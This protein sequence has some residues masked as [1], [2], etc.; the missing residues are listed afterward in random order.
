MLRWGIY[1]L[2]CLM[3]VCTYSI[4]EAGI[5]S[6][7]DKVEQIQHIYQLAKGGTTPFMEVDNSIKLGMTNTQIGDYCRKEKIDL[8]DPNLLFAL[9]FSEKTKKVS[10][11]T[12]LTDYDFIL[13]DITNALG[14]P[15]NLIKFLQSGDYRIEYV[16]NLHPTIPYGPKHVLAFYFTEKGYQKLSVKILGEGM[17]HQR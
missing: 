13:D 2:T 3:L 15:E 7:S 8:L 4:C 17:D 1:L 10:E 6:A 11:I 5:N 16:I 14:R 9:K 12:D